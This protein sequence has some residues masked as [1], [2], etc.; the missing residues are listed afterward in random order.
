[1]ERKN[2]LNIESKVIFAGFCK[3]VSPFYQA[4]DV[5]VFPS[6]WE[7]LGMVA[8]EAQASGLPCFVSERIPS[9]VDIGAGLFFQLNLD[10]GVSQWADRILEKRDY[11]REEQ[12]QF[13]RRAGYD[14][15]TIA[16]DMEKFYLNLDKDVY[17]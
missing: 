6:L 10:A 5:F 17:L 9:I 12:I 14:A 4:M 1:M 13:L 3:E 16:Q 8:V 7:G 15:I 2:K 11:I